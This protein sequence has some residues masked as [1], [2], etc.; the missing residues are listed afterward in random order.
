MNV[1]TK[2]GYGSTFMVLMLMVVFLVAEICVMSLLPT[3]NPLALHVVV[4]VLFIFT[5]RRIAN[6]RRHK[7]R[8][9]LI[10]PVTG[11]PRSRET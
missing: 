4:I 11:Q 10:D 3:L 1:Y 2:M 8:H 5:L 9:H 6:R 7:N